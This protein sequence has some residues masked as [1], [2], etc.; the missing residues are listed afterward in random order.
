MITLS[1]YAFSYISIALLRRR[2]SNLT[3]YKNIC[4][5]LNT[6]LLLKDLLPEVMSPL[7][8]AGTTP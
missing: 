6:L 5:E 2:E 4:Q 7:P 1:S 3:T 8:L